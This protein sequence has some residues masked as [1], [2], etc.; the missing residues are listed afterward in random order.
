MNMRTAIEINLVNSIAGTMNLSKV[1]GI[2]SDKE[3]ICLD[4]LDDGTWQLT[5]NTKTIPDFSDVQSLEVV[6]IED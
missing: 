4:K 3:M 2:T 6:R 1:I 5:Y